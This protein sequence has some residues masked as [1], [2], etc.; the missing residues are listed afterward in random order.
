MLGA[1]GERDMYEEYPPGPAL[2]AVVVPGEGKEAACLR[3]SYN[4]LGT[5]LRAL[6]SCSFHS[7][8]VRLRILFL[9]TEEENEA[10]ER[11]TRCQYW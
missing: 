8:L 3:S 2:E 1:G 10:Q 7:G 5:E 6:R 4:E 9:F 11:K